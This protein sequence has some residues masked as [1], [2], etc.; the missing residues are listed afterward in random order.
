MLHGCLKL[1][2]HKVNLVLSE[3]SLE[4]GEHLSALSR[5]TRMLSLLNFVSD[6]Y[7][8]RVEEFVTCLQLREAVLDLSD[9]LL[10]EA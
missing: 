4:S 8:R 6:L 5:L 3:V 7:E 2:D 10:A 9:R 1:A